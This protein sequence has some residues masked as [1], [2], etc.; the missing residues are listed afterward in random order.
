MDTALAVAA[1]V[2]VLL[3]LNSWRIQLR[4]WRAER[5]STQAGQTGLA[6]EPPS[7]KV[8]IGALDRVHQLAEPLG[9]LAVT[10]ERRPDTTILLANR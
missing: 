3:V 7:Q 6:V 2:M 1:T 9:Q 8:E 5:H 10:R 4:E